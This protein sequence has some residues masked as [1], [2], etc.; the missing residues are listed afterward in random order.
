MKRTMSDSF[1]RSLYNETIHVE[2]LQIG[3]SMSNAQ[4]WCT[5]FNLL[6]IS[7][8]SEVVRICMFWYFICQGLES[9]A[10]SME[11]SYNTQC[12]ICNWVRSTM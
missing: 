10:V 9:E 2:E 3:T 7:I 5:M 8:T 12:W 1:T 4:L 6:N 11:V